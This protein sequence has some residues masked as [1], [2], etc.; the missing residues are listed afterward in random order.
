M[1]FEAALGLAPPQQPGGGDGDGAPHPLLI[2]QPRADRCG[3]GLC[4]CPH[5]AHS[6][7]ASADRM[8]S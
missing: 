6:A 8:D 4:V 5:A 3:A 2:L 1:D 7:H